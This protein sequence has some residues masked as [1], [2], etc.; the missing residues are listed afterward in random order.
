M[1]VTVVATIVPKP[2]HHD[3]VIAIIEASIP[4][5]HAEP[6]CEL[7]ALQTGTDRLVMIEKWASMELLQA[8]GA[9]EALKEAHAAQEGKLAGEVDVQLL[10]PHPVGGAQGEL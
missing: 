7:Y 2:E 3:E 6:G 9:G 4:K 10:R 1:S 5:V 8:H